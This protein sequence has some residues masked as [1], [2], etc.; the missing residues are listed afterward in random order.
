MELGFMAAITVAKDAHEGQVRKYTNEPYLSHPFA[1]A[2]LVASVTSDDDMIIAALL[3]DVVEDSDVGID[4]IFGLFGQRVGSMVSDLTDISKPEDGNRK[5]R[6][7]IDM[8]HTASATP[9]A[10]TIK[11]A[12]LIDNSKTIVPLDPGFAKVYMEEKRRLLEVLS[13]GDHSLFRIA[14][15]IVD[16][17]FTE[18][19]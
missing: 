2:G 8:I 6:K 15:N 19:D 10:K 13:D 7:Y 18:E 14:S 5:K 1:V 16:E 9:E 3:H 12:D 17:Y 11:L 4:K